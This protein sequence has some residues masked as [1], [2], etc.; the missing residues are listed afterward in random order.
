MRSKTVNGEGKHETEVKMIRKGKILLLFLATVLSATG[1]LSDKEAPMNEE[2]ANNQQTIEIEQEDDIEVHKEKD[3]ILEKNSEDRFL[4]EEI[5][6]E[7]NFHWQFDA[8]ME[9]LMYCMESTDHIPSGI[10][11]ELKEACIEALDKGH[12]EEFLTE[13]SVE[14]TILTMDE[15][16][17]YIARDCTA[18]LSLYVQDQAKED[19]WIGVAI[20]EDKTDIIVR[21]REDEATESYIYYMFYAHFN[22]DEIWYNPAVRA[23]G[24]EEVSFI[25]YNGEV[26][27]VL[28]YRNEDGSLKGVA[29]HE[30]RNEEKYQTIMYLE[31]GGEQV[32]QTIFY[33]ATTM[34]MNGRWLEGATEWPEYPE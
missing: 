31:I 12:W 32:T 28:P 8:Y 18:A 21:F 6:V 26:L 9:P 30:Y 27:M 10:W 2:I 29:I 15:K 14:Q 1:C 16:E 19:E 34:G 7:D 4:A 3:S 5:P 11:G 23:L 33:G 20:S 13:H 25:E 17:S 22:N 24:T